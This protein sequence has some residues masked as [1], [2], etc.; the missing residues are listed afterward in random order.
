MSLELAAGG[1]CR[2]AAARC[3]RSARSLACPW[4]A[5]NSLQARYTLSARLAPFKRPQSATPFCLRARRTPLRT[6]ACCASQCWLPAALTL[7]RCAATAAPSAN[8]RFGV[9]THLL[10]ALCH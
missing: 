9:R 3:D 1:T 10:A 2:T 4:Q 6:P 8:I 5:D 7:A